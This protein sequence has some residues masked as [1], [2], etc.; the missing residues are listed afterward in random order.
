[1]RLKTSSLAVSSISERAATALAT[2]FVCR[3]VGRLE[4]KRGRWHCSST[5]FPYHWVRVGEEVAQH[6]Q[7]ALGL[8]QLGVDVPHLRDAHRGGLSH[9]GVGIL[10]N[11]QPPA[12]TCACGVMCA[13][14]CAKTTRKHEEEV[15][16]R[17]RRSEDSPGKRGSTSRGEPRR[18]SK[19]KSSGR[20]P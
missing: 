15:G 1:L 6:V 2:T 9:V 12:L 4:L 19:R 7:E 8:D 5:G 10:H 3:S 20:V 16:R 17:R 13:R 11:N 18:G 14:R